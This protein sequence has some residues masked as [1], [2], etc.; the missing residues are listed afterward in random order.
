MEEKNTANVPVKVVTKG[1][2]A[3]GYQLGTAKTEQNRITITGGKSKVEQVS[4]CSLPTKTTKTTRLLS[5][6]PK[7]PCKARKTAINAPWALPLAKLN[8]W[9]YTDLQ[10]LQGV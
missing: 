5:R 2:V 3:D 4:F 6:S 1:E 7:Q 8:V 9:A 10:Y